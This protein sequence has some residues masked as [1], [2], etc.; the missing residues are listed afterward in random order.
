[1]KLV[2]TLPAYN[3]AK[4]IADV[5]HQIPRDIKGIDQVEVIVIDDGSVDSTVQISKNAGAEVV[6]HH[7]NMGVGTA[8]S[9]GIQVALE[10]GADIIITIDADG[11]FNPHDIP[12]LIE[13][14]LKGEAD[15]TTASRFLDPHLVPDMP[16]IKIF[17]NRIFTKIVNYLTNQN[18]KDTQCGFRAYTKDT[19][20]RLVLFGK[21][22]YTQEVFLDIAKQ[23]LRIVEV[24]LKVKGQRVG[25]SRVVSNIFSYGIKALI[26]ILRSVRDYKP[27]AFFGIISL[28]FIFSGVFIALFLLQHWLF[29]GQISPYKSLTT[30]AA[31]LVI[32]GLQMSVLALLADM[33]GREMKL[34]RDVLYYI[35][36]E[37]YNKK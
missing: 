22:T 27:L 36:V 14:I 18:F 5:I 32:I 10:R 23:N 24:P 4:T 7:E 6:S 31:A 2:V 20:I 30:A 12:T 29:T 11:Q 19:A 13:P 21:F 26:I 33:V 3:E 25:K 35:K 9:T 8:F 37:K 15:F 17:G 1:M 28:A 16:R 34:M